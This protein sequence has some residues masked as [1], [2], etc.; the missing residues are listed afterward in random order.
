MPFNQMMGLPVELTL[1]ATAAGEGLEIQ[2]VR[3]LKS[4]R[5]TTHHIEPQPLQPGKN[6]LAGM[7]GDLFEMEARLAIG[8]AKKI[9]FNLRGVPVDYDALTH[10][11][12]CLGC[13][14]TVPPEAGEIYLHIFVDRASVD[15]YGGDGT[16]YLPT[17]KAIPPE[18][19]TLGLSCEGG[20]ARIVS[21]QVYDLKSAWNPE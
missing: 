8:D 18:N 17:A 21:L 6:P 2:P 9:S 1:H 14:G 3:E 13:A 15:I 5:K 10:K 7:R 16:L 19:Q 20:E 12:S 4:L 11:L